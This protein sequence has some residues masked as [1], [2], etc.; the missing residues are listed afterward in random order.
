M[1]RVD[2]EPVA[3]EIPHNESE[4]LA[5]IQSLQIIETPIE[6]R[7]ERITRLVSRVLAVPIVAISIVDGNREW[8]KSIY[9]SD[10][11]EIPREAAFGAATILKDGIHIVED[12]AK[13]DLF[14]GNPLLSGETPVQSYAGVPITIAK[15]VNVGVLGVYV[16]APRQFTDDDRQ[17]LIDFCES[18]TSEIKARLVQNI[19][20]TNK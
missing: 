2:D 15:N 13:T 10:I 18:V 20:E 8:F 12:V 19:Y 7:F 1:N 16:H 11:T 17:A 6:K 14:R 4:R 9:G 3:I 5:F